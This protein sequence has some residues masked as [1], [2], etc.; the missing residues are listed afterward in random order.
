MGSCP[1]APRRTNREAFRI[2]AWISVGSTRH[3]E[4][5]LNF[6]KLRYNRSSLKFVSSGQGNMA[7]KRLWQDVSEE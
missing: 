1:L 3:T 6:F 5:G 4:G 7:T 2:G